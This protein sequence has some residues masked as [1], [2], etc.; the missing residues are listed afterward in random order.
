M[1]KAESGILKEYERI[2]DAS[3]DIICTM[4]RDGMFIHISNAATRILGYETDEL[5]GKPYL[6]FIEPQYQQATVA[7]MARAINGQT[8]SFFDNKVISKTGQFITIRWSMN[9]NNQAQALFC[10]GRD[11][12][13]RIKYEYR[14]EQSERWY[15]NLFHHN[16]LPMWIIDPDTKQFLEVNEKA[17]SH[18]GYTREE[19][20]RMTAHDIRP[21][22]D[23]QRLK[24]IQKIREGNN[25]VHKGRW[26]HIKKNGD[27]IDVEV[28]AHQIEFNGNL[29]SLVL[30][31]DITDRLKLELQR[32]EEER[33]KIALINTT[34]DMIWSIDTEYNL[35]AANRS[36]INITERTS[37]H[38]IQLGDNMLLETSYP[39]EHIK[40]W[41]ALYDRA[42]SGESFHMQSLDIYT[43]PGEEIWWETSFNPIR[44][45]QKIIGVACHSRNIT[46]N[47][48]YQSELWQLNQ[49]LETAQK[50]A[51]LGYWELNLQN[52]ELFWTHEVYNIWGR[53]PSTFQP[54]FE[55]FLETFHPEDRE[56]FLKK[57]A[58]VLNGHDSLD[59]EHRIQLPDGSIRYVHEKGNLFKDQFGKAI[60]YSGTVQDITQRKLHEEALEKANRELSERADQL[61][62]SNAELERFAFIASHDLQEPLRMVSSF[63]QLVEKRYKD[64][65]DEAGRQYIN[66]AVSGAERM[67]KLINDLLAYSRLEN[68]SVEFTEVDVKAVLN[69]VAT[70]L[71]ESIAENN[72]VL[73]IDPMPVVSRGNY[74]GLVQLFQNLIGNA[75]KYRRE[76]Q[77]EINI[78]A[79]EEDG[80][81]QFAIK[82]NGIG[83]EPDYF[84]KIFV[85]FQRL[86]N[87]SEFSGTGI[88]LAICK[89]I[90][91]QHNGKIWVYSKEKVG[92][93]F[94]FTIKK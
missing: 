43:E 30:S 78:S 62:R 44:E 94:Y 55:L 65:L 63:L 71:Q 5:V 79:K 3:P 28:T 22:A 14:L 11:V 53:H 34:S 85:I 33:N 42:L 73:N 56:I 10:I 90:A 50:L 40:Y 60:R 32:K 15:R 82:D 54:S 64:K 47:R 66:Y 35:L 12:T 21:E 88:G 29:A 38:S 13:E 75:L 36:F 49:K 87:M 2:M 4:N 39:V 16:P 25:L 93:T 41:K 52:N 70:N 74:S 67:K 61:S 89:K 1:S 20:L 58:L 46:Q 9:W 24:K 76:I 8:V 23:R 51:K 59:F 57:R 27:I 86:H 92:S 84:E 7:A 18:Y 45:D 68:T 80:Y 72:A 19:F 91:E 83:I 31:N 48:K 77:P 6:G 26:K 69:E 81:W 37:H 17:I